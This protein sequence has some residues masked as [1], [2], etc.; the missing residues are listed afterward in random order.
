MQE[1]HKS[2]RIFP[3]SSP[4]YEDGNIERELCAK[5]VTLD[6]G[7]HERDHN[8][9]VSSFVCH[10]GGCTSLFENVVDYE[11]HYAT[12][13]KNVC[14]ECKKILP[15]IRLLELHILETHD[16]I[17]KALSKS[18]KMYECLVESCKRKFRSDHTRRLHLID[19]HQYPKTFRFHSKRK[20]PKKSHESKPE[21]DSATNSEDISVVAMEL[22]KMSFPKED[23]NM[24]VEEGR[25]KENS[26]EQ[27]EAQSSVSPPSKF[28]YSYST[29][30]IPKNFSFGRRGR[31]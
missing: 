10:I 11:N 13:H 21:K 30:K 15:S 24:D 14:K 1:K 31:R 9:R 26:F 19:Y 29:D 3:P 5:Q 22:E 12:V 6:E 7:D 28:K 23:V 20:E 18:K 8:Q 25:D 17:F 2:K 4:F 27:K 16:S